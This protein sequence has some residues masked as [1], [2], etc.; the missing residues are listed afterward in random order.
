MTPNLILS[1][2]PK[3]HLGVGEDH[4]D[5]GARDVFEELHVDKVALHRLRQPPT[6]ALDEF[7]RILALQGLLAHDF[8]HPHLERFE[9]EQQKEALE[10]GN[11]HFLVPQKEPLGRAPAFRDRVGAAIKDRD[12]LERPQVNLQIETIVGIL[13]QDDFHIRRVNVLKVGLH[14]ETLHLLDHL[15]LHGELL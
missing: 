14:Q 3:L 15:L 6:D 8:A 4:F 1:N 12:L 2:K 9:L 7:F 5:V 13:G 11:F 10:H